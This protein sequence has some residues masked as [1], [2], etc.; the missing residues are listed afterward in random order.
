MNSITNKKNNEGG[1]TEETMI[2]SL[3]EGLLKI[4]DK[5]NK[6]NTFKCI[7]T[8]DILEEAHRQ[9]ER[10]EEEQLDD[11]A[12]HELYESMKYS[13]GSY[14]SASV[15]MMMAFGILSAGP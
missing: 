3:N 10:M 15:G 8:N 4:F 6:G 13:L 11:H 12:F 9:T 1:E 7:R 14:F 5:H 2:E